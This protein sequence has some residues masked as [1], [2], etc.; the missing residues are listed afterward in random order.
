MVKRT[1]SAGF[2]L[3]ELVITFAI[4]ALLLLAATPFA[5]SWI[6][7]NRQLMVQSQLLEGIGQARA[8]AMR[9]PGAQA[10]GE[11]VTRL[12]YDTDGNRLSVEWTA[13]GQ[14]AWA[15]SLG[16][17]PGLALVQADAT[18]F[19]DPDASAGASAFSCAAFDSRGLRLPSAT[20][21]ASN[22]RISIGVNSQELL[23]VHLL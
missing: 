7:S 22:E 5:R 6:D 16:T 14:T 10:P 17:V 11:P 2:T 8:L 23:Y 21:C 20:G 12:K 18:D 3:I 4:M 19:A 15:L 13:D 1:A 9:N